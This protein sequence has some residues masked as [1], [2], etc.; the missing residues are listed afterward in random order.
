MLSDKGVGRNR[1]V[2]GLLQA[3]QCLN[4]VVVVMDVSGPFRLTE[5]Y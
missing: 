2:G 3:D 4:N 5:Y 1:Q